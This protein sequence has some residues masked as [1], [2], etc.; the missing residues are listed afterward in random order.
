MRITSNLKFLL[1][2]IILFPIAMVGIWLLPLYYTKIVDFLSLPFSF[3]FSKDLFK[4][5]Q[6]ILPYSPLWIIGFFLFRL[7]WKYS[8]SFILMRAE[9]IYDIFS[10]KS[11]LAVHVF[12]SHHTASG[13]DANLPSTTTV[14]HYA[15]RLRDGKIFYNEV[16]SYEMEIIAGKAG[17]GGF[18]SFEN[19]V[20]GSQDLRKS[21][22]KLSRKSGLK[23]ALN[24]THQKTSFD[25]KTI[26]KIVADFQSKDKD[27]DKSKSKKWLTMGDNLIFVSYFN[28]HWDEGYYVINVNLQSDAVEWKVKI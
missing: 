6:E 22:Q 20:L 5:I 15:I 10:D 9:N 26:K 4:K 2:F 28:T 11:S 16:M 24:L 7:A 18:T 19:N 25:R 8:K 27:I 23:L 13:S 3:I 14:L 17:W 12:S 1:G 21:L